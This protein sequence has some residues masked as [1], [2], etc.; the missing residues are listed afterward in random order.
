MIDF[1]PDAMLQQI[2]ALQSV[3]DMSDAQLLLLARSV[4]GDAALLCIEEMIRVDM[5]ELLEDL[6]RIA[7]DAAEL[8]A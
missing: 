4:A 1:G 2:R 3:L 8:A 5:Q 6:L 7:A